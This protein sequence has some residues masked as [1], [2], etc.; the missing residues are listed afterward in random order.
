MHAG[1]AE[2]ADADPVMLCVSRLRIADRRVGRSPGAFL[3]FPDCTRNHTAVAEGPQAQGKTS[4][5]V[6]YQDGSQPSALGHREPTAHKIPAVTTPAMTSSAMTPAAPPCRS[7]QPIGPGFTT[8][9]R[10]KIRKASKTPSTETCASPYSASSCPATSSITIHAGSPSIRA[11]RIAHK[12][13]SV[14][15]AAAIASRRGLIVS[16]NT[17]GISVNAD[18]TVPGAIGTKPQPSPLAITRGT[19]IT[20]RL[21]CWAAKRDETKA[22][23]NGLLGPLREQG[24]RALATACT[25]NH[26]VLQHTLHVVTCFVDRDQLDPV[27]H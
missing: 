9:S 17:P 27:Q 26:N 18:A 11:A 2:Q 16:S 19:F 12:P 6:A 24:W 23:C 13:A 7:A 25:V 22:A 21:C 3:A 8:S 10:R 20:C 1:C 14:M 15:E 4:Q 5:S